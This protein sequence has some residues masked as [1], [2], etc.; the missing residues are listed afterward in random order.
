MPNS[1]IFEGQPQV[2]ISKHGLAFAVEE[3]LLARETASS[4]AELL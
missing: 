1:K 4:V 3:N 2:D